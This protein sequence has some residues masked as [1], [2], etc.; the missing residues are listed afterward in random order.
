MQDGSTPLHHAASNGHAGVARVL[1]EHGAMGNARNIVSNDV[2]AVARCCCPAACAVLSR[3]TL[4]MV[5]V[6]Y[7]GGVAAVV[8]KR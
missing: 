7:V 6:R 2:R 4:P 3:A 8:V 1:L 5:H